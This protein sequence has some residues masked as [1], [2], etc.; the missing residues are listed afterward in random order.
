MAPQPSVRAVRTTVKLDGYHS[1]LSRRPLSPMTHAD[2]HVSL[3]TCSGVGISLPMAPSAAPSSLILPSSS[4]ATL[5]ALADVPR[6]ATSM[7]TAGCF[8]GRHVCGLAAPARAALSAA[9]ADERVSAPAAVV[10]S[11]ETH[12]P[13]RGGVA[14]GKD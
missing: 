2:R 1:H 4:S 10:A 12:A 3:R 7:S 11:G 5:E 8:T 6:T 9:T 14:G 13:D